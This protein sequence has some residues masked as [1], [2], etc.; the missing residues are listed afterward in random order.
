MLKNP[1]RIKEFFVFEVE[2]ENNK[3]FMAIF[4]LENA[5]K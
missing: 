3:N 1:F 5:K 2:N 4:L